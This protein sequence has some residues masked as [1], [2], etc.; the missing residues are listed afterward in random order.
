M[1]PS[2]HH[3]LLF[4]TVVEKFL[5]VHCLAS[6]GRGCLLRDYEP[7][8]KERI[9]LQDAAQNAACLKIEARVLGCSA[10]KFLA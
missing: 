6:I 1:Y 10:K 8:D 2:Q 3:E 4:V 9:R 7:G 5:L